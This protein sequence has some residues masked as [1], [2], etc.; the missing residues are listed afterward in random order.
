MLIFLGE[1]LVSAN[2][3]AFS[4]YADYRQI[5][6]LCSKGR[7]DEAERFVKGKDRNKIVGSIGNRGLHFSAL[8][9]IPDIV[10]VFLQHLEGADQGMA[11]VLPE[12]VG[13]CW[14]CNPGK[15]KQALFECSPNSTALFL[16]YCWQLKIVTK[17]QDL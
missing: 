2:F 9:G 13:S 17:R 14:C 8:L 10:A 3:Y 7:F 1:K 12:V 16:L 6:Y 15:I 4:N 5:F 11:N